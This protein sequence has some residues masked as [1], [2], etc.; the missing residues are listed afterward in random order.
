L[1]VYA[2]NIE[3]VLDRAEFYELDILTEKFNKNNRE[4]WEQ[5]R[6]ISYIIAQTQAYKKKYKLTDILQFTWDKEQKNTPAFTKEEIEER[7]K[8]FKERIEMKENSESK[9][10]TSEQFFK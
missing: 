9:S 4:S 2:D 10:I 6:F 3:Y 5:T 1:I 7:I 8:G